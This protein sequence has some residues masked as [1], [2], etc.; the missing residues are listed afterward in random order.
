MGKYSIE[1]LEKINGRYC[2]NYVLRQQDVNMANKY[3]ELIEN[4]RKESPCVGDI[5]EFTNEYGDYYRNAHIENIYDDGTAYIC[6][7]P[8]SPFIHTNKDGDGIVCNTSGGAWERIPLGEM[9]N[10]NVREKRFWDWGSVGACV[11]GGVEFEAYVNVW[12]YAKPNKFISKQGFPYTTKEYNRMRINYI[13]EERMK[14]DDRYSYLGNCIAWRTEEELQ[15]WLRTYR[16][17]IFQYGAGSMMVW[18]W[19]EEMHSL[20]PVEFDA[21]D[22]PED[23]LMNNARILRCKRKYDEKAHTVHTY[24]VWYWDEPN[25]DWRKAAMEQN[26]IRDKF[27]TLDWKTPT[28]NYALT[29]LKSGKIKRENLNFLYE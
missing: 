10:V 15:A 18:Y 4:S 26:E 27:Y 11:D 3:V 5:V 13:S 29:E 23:T 20:S 9:I 22:L 12:Q 6:E 8:Y 28:N 19:K 21:L 7:Q 1:S 16:A 2:R 25:K 14:E 17:E 24:W